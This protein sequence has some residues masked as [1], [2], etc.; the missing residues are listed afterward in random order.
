MSEHWKE[1][2]DL[3]GLQLR[4][5]VVEAHS[6]LEIGERNQYRVKTIYHKI[7]YTHFFRSSAISFKGSNQSNELHNGRKWPCSVSTRF[8]KLFTDFQY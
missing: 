8:Q 3:N 7:K 1:L 4:F 6:F 5:S 2:T